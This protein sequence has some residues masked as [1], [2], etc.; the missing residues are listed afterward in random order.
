[1]GLVFWTSQKHRGSQSPDLLARTQC[2][3]KNLALYAGG[4][5][6]Q[7]L[8]RDSRGTIFI[9]NFNFPEYP[10]SSVSGPRSLASF[11]IISNVA[12]F[13]Q[14]Y[15]SLEMLHRRVEI[16]KQDFRKR[17]E[18]NPDLLCLPL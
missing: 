1:L 5:H 13:M 6:A 15:I 2:V 17:G 14:C 16:K 4:C 12:L 9:L 11:S 10:E 18:V 7:S 8:L 3:R